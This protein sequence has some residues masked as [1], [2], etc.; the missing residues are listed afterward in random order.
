MSH[1]Y[2]LHTKP[3][4]ERQVEA[5]LHGRDIEVFF[6]TIPVPRRPHR[7]SER[8]FF[9]GYLFAHTDLDV[10][11]L[12]SLH[13]APGMRGVVMFGGIPAKVDDHIVAT[14]RARLAQVNPASGA[15]Q[16]AIDGD[17][18][19]LEQ[20]DRVLITSGPL[21]DLDAVFDRR[22]SAAGRVRVLLRALERW[23]SVDIE[24]GALRKQV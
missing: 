24:A 22:L 5:F 23:T 19:I 9:P 6:P 10:V 3:H 16:V 4:K 20:G 2:A 14:L 7:P 21:A 8:A 12:W 17:G 1:W 18:E 15:G 13:Y 11:G